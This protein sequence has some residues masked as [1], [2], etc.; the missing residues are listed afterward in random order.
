MQ[1]VSACSYKG[2]Y[3]E[4]HGGLD[5]G[6]AAFAFEILL[7]KLLCTDPKFLCT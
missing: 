4:L 2:M 7:K 5:L 3:N 6:H 1:E